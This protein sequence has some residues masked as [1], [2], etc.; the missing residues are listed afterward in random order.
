[1]ICELRHD[2]D[3]IMLAEILPRGELLD[4]ALHVQELIHHDQDC[5]SKIAAL[6][7]FIDEAVESS[8][9]DMNLDDMWDIAKKKVRRPRGN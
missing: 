2:R 8:I 9:G 6:Q 1:M 7:T 5:L 3:G 4:V